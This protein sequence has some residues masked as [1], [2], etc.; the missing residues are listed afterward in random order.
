MVQTKAFYIKLK[1]ET[2]PNQRTAQVSK[3]AVFQICSRTIVVKF[4]ISQSLRRITLHVLKTA[5]S[6]ANLR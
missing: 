6:T 1:T 4:L 2:S 5:E 3:T